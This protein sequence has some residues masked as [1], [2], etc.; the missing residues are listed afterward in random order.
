[1]NTVI[2]LTVQS[3]IITVQEIYAVVRIIR[4][5]I[6]PLNFAVNIV[7]DVHTVKSVVAK[8]RIWIVEMDIAVILQ[9][10][11]IILQV[12]CAMDLVRVRQKIPHKMETKPT[13]TQ[14]KVILA[15]FAHRIIQLV[16]VH[17]DL[18]IIWQLIDLVGVIVHVAVQH[19]NMD[20][21]TEE[22]EEMEKL[23]Q[24]VVEDLGE[25]YKIVSK[26]HHA[27]KMLPKM[28]NLIQI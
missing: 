20:Q 3:G 19:N 4:T 23:E 21:P 25:M 14:I 1:V 8:H 2:I 15:Y 7:Q 6:Q 11:I 22:V 13:I 17:Q 16:L 27:H 5:M 9:H 10:H 24:A 26:E 28:G 18:H 12:D